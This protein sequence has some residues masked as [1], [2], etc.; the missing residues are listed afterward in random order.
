M[1][2][3]VSLKE[4][5]YSSLAKAAAVSEA[6]EPSEKKESKAVPSF[7]TSNSPKD[8]NDIS[9]E[10]KIKAENETA[11]EDKSD[12]QELSSEEK[13]EVK[14]LEKIDAEVRRHEQ[15]HLAAGGSLVRGGASFSFQRGPDGQ[16]YAVGGEV[17]IE[18]AAEDDPQATV[19][20][21]QQVK[22][23]A[24]A[25]AEPSAQD[26]SVASRASAL[27][28][29]ARSEMLSEKNDNEGDSDDSSVKISGGKA[30]SSQS[31]DRDNNSGKT[32]TDQDDS[33]SKNTQASAFGS[34]QQKYLN[35]NSYSSAFNAY[36]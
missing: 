9:K 11:T 27:E 16:Q 30:D 29:Q 34:L 2:S 28:A 6:S 33:G 31:P 32:D 4:S 23:A 3:N 5:N 17:N 21:M 1:I 8:R 15:A 22:R 26:R 20:K 7:E 35:Y 12:T 13:Q 19:Q 10:S 25:P 24:L 14:E 18:M 36:A